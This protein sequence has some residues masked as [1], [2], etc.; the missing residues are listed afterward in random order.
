VS[1]S[2]LETSFWQNEMRW[3][4]RKER[5]CCLCAKERNA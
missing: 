2:Y 4:E 5:K 1:G 3:G